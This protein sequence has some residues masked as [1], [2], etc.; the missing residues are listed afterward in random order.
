MDGLVHAVGQVGGRQLADAAGAGAR[1]G[2]IDQRF[3]DTGHP[4]G[5]LENVLGHV[6]N[7]LGVVFILQV[8]RQAGDAGDRVADFVGDAGGQST[9]RGQPFVVQ[10]LLLQQLKIGNIFHQY[11]SVR[12]LSLAADSA[13][14]LCRLIQRACPSLHATRF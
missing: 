12:W 6:T 4:L 5:L 7:F 10:Q 1:M 14:V 3:H 8:L 13:D 2:K 9:D 11:D